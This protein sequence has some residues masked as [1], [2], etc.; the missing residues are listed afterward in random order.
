VTIASRPFGGT[1]WRAYNFDF[2]E[3]GT[4]MFLQ[5]GLD[6]PNQIDPVQ[7]IRLCAQTA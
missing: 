1:G 3:A 4:E 5:I 2:G 7:E 6:S